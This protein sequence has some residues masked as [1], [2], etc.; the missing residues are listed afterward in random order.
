MDY[1]KRKENVL[2][3][4]CTMER[5][6]AKDIV[7]RPVR[8]CH[9]NTFAGEKLLKMPDRED[10]SGCMEIINNTRTGSNVEMCRIPYTVTH[11]QYWHKKNPKYAISAFLSYPEAMGCSDG[12]YFWEALGTAKEDIERFFGD[13]AEQDMEKKII[14]ALKRE[15]KKCNTKT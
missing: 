11:R 2:F 8:S 12:E 1:S 14:K 7:F 13:S 9:S 4:P 5:E 10:R 15:V 6:I 3:I